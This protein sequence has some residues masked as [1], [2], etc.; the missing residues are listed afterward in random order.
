MAERTDPRPRRKDDTRVRTP[1]RGKA[2][3]VVAVLVS[4]VLLLGAAAAVSVWGLL[5]RPAVEVASGRPVQVSIPSGASTAEIGELLARE[6]VVRNAN[7]FRVQTRLLEADGELRAGI[8]D[9]TTG[10]DYEPVIEQLQAGP[11]IVYVDVTIPEGYVV[12]Q[13]AERVAENTG[14]SAEEFVTLAKSGGVTEFPGRPY[15]ESVYQGSLEGYLFPKTYRIKEGTT[16]REVIEMMLDQFEREI[17]QVDIGAVEEAGLSLHEL[18]TIASMIEREARVA[19][20]R[21]LISS[22]IHNRLEQGTRLEIDATIEY[23]LPGNRFRLSNEDLQLES[24]YNTYRNAGLPPGPIANPGLASLQAAADPAETDYIYY[25]LTAEDGSH[26]F[27]ATYEEFL[28]AKE[29]S[30]EVFGE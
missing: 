8:Y 29:K 23:V 6:G 18:V 7:M 17:A 5:L 11:P 27:A 16:A 10:M 1:R 13:I 15:L 14:I 21:P 25:V 26:T 3:A 22:V 30:K 4:V 2:G 9:F 19:D 12:E 24:P 20:E 28:A